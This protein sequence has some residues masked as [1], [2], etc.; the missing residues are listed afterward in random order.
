[1]F[2]KFKFL[3]F[4]LFLFCFMATIYYFL[5]YQY[6]LSILYFLLTVINYITY[7]ENGKLI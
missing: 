5:K 4:S 1:M 7:K 6:N 2:K 3:V